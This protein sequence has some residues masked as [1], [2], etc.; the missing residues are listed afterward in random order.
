MGELPIHE[1]WSTELHISQAWERKTDGWWVDVP[2]LD[3][4]GMA[5]LMVNA[6]ARFITMTVV[7][8]NNDEFQVAYHWDRAR[9]GPKEKRMI[10]LRSHSVGGATPHR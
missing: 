5:K 3:Q 8:Q 2:S 9:I 4:R 7:P 10:T 1:Q 6:G